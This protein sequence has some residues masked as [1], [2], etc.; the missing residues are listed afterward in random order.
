MRNGFHFIVLS[1]MIVLTGCAGFG[2]KASSS[3]HE[4]AEKPADLF[5]AASHMNFNDGVDAHEASTLA[6]IYFL[7]VYGGCGACM[8]VEDRG[9]NWYF[10]CSVGYAGADR[11]GISVSKTG[12]RIT[13]VSGP[14]I[15][16]L[17]QLINAKDPV[18]RE[19]KWYK[20]QT[21]N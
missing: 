3:S 15:T 16:N 5:E 6:W 19:T 10:P 12:C 18:W 2:R 9:T 7:R 4:L 8:L 17:D 21:S 13:C 14:E 20:Y 1:G 11:P